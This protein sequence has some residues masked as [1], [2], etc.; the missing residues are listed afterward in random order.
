MQG[1]PEFQERYGTSI[2]ARIL[3]FHLLL[4]FHLEFNICHW[5]HPKREEKSR[6]CC[7]LLLMTVPHNPMYDSIDYITVVIIF[8]Y[9]ITQIRK[10]PLGFFGIADMIS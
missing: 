6:F 3:I 7:S 8:T 9:L 4:L 5:L 10:P 2:N 1:T